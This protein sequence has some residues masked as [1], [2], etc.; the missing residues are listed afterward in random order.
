M[1]TI[2]IAILLLIPTF[3]LADDVSKTA[4]VEQ[5]MQLSN[6]EQNMK[7]MFD[8]LKTVQIA[9]MRKNVAVPTQDKAAAEEIQTRMMDVMASHMSFEKLRPTMVKAYLDVFTEEEID[10]ILGFYQ[11]PAGKAMLQKS[12]QLMVHI[13][14]AAQQQMGDITAE[15]KKITD[16][17]NAKYHPK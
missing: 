13:M 15:L 9:T 8:Q 3:V 11:S 2:A 16:E 7:A 1:R 14:G 10:G 17:V 12:P 5:L 4:K 6:T